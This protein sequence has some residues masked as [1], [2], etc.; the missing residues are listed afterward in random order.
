MTDPRMRSEL[1]DLTPE[2]A[3]ARFLLEVDEADP[4][5]AQRLDAWLDRDPAHRE[6]WLRAQA[7]WSSFDDADEH[8]ELDLPRRRARAARPS[9]SL[10]P[11]L[12]AA[13]S[14]V[15]AVGLGVMVLQR[16]GAPANSVSPPAAVQIADF[17]TTSQR[18]LVDLPDGSK[19]T[20]APGS[21]LDLEFSN[22]ERRMRLVRGRA[23]FDVAHDAKRPFVVE[24]EDRLVTALGTRF[25]VRSDSEGLGIA[26]LEGRVQVELR[27]SSPAQAAVVLRPGQELV[28]GADRREV[29][30]VAEVTQLEAW[31]DTRIAF[32]DRPLGEVVAQLNR[33]SVQQMVIVDPSVAALR[34]SGQFRAGD[35]QRFAR[36]LAR[37][38]PVRAVQ[39]GPVRIKLVR[40]E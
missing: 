16:G 8:R 27:G 35:P 7:V 23:Y 1:D 20:L 26:L 22:D 25:D 14:V 12:L 5:Q 13:A 40:A 33:Y 2:Q 19:A 32:D 36:G 15:G 30:R 10:A 11:W 6:A 4:V 3:A 39:D 18:R 31:R 21:A 17:E 28:V 29:V 9:R 37:I 38:Y 24:A 34:V